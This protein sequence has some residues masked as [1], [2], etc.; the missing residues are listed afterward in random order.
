LDVKS[1]FISMKIF[2]CHNATARRARL[3]ASGQFTGFH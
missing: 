1:C 2:Q 3:S